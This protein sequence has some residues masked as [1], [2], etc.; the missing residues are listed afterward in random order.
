[1]HTELE[2]VRADAEWLCPH[3]Y[4]A[5]HPEQ[6]WICNSSICMQRRG[7][8]PTG[9]AIFQ[10]QGNG[11]PSVA[12]WLQAQLK[13]GKVTNTPTPA[14]PPPGTAAAKPDA[15]AAAAGTKGTP[16]SSSF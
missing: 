1:M 4:E 7:M 15:V 5:E 10:A 6:H 9:I 12:H 2:E 11:F 8:R 16:R 3:C 14:P 13:A